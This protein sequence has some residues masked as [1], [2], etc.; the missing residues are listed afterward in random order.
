VLRATQTRQGSEQGGFSD[1][2]FAQN[3]PAFA[4][5]DLPV[6]RMADVSIANAQRQVTRENQRRFMQGATHV[7]LDR[8]EIKTQARQ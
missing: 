4:R 2:I 5:I 6:Q 8:A 7:F 3:C 1:A